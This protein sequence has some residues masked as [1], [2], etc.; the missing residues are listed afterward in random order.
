LFILHFIDSSSIAL[1][2]YYNYFYI[3][4][5]HPKL[6]RITF[7]YHP[8]N[9]GLLDKSKDDVET[10]NDLGMLSESGSAVSVL[11]LREILL[12]EKD[13][14]DMVVSLY[15]LFYHVSQTLFALNDLHLKECCI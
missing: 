8:I 10:L 13:D 14:A 7:N 11:G 4:I 12:R 5:D 2:V 3:N 15:Y 1:Y 6:D 9:A